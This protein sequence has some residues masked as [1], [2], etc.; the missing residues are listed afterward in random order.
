ML[1]GPCLVIDIFL[2]PLDFLVPLLDDVVLLA[3]LLVVAVLCP[4]YSGRSSIRTMASTIRR[5]VT[6]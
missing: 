6:H 2:V 1:S 3:D 5:T 4:P